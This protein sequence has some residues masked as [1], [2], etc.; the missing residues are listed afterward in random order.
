MKLDDLAKFRADYLETQ[1][2]DSIFFNLLW[3]IAQLMILPRLRTTL[4][5]LEN[6]TVFHWRQK[7]SSRSSNKILETP[8]LKAIYSAT[9]PIILPP[10][11]VLQVLLKRI[12]AVSLILSQQLAWMWKYPSSN[13]ASLIPPL[14]IWLSVTPSIKQ[15]YKGKR[16]RRQS[17]RSASLLVAPTA[18]Q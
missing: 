17:G 7:N 12:M 4:S 15:K 9:T 5:F 10:H 16:R 8:R 11:I 14:G 1:G 6:T 3:L 18:I 2:N 13:G